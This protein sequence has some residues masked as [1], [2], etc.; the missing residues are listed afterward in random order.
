MHAIVKN[1]RG[2]ADAEIEIAPIALIC[3]TNGQGKTSIARAIGAAASGRVAPFDKLLKKDI[4]VLL[5]HG[6]KSGSV[7]LAGDN[8]STSIAWPK[9][10][11]TSDGL[12]IVSSSIAAGLVDFMTMKEDD[13]YKYLID[14]L[15]AE[16][17]EAD[18]R[19]HMT[20][21]GIEENAIDA[22]WKVIQDRDWVSAHKRAVTK[23][24]EL[25]GAWSQVSGVSFGTKIIDEWFPADWHDSMADVELTS[26]ENRI[27]TIRK[28]LEDEIGSSAVSAAERE[29]LQ[30]SADALEE[31]E[32]IAT[33]KKILV[34]QVEAVLKEVERKL[35][36]TTNPAGAKDFGCPHCDG[37]VQITVISGMG[38]YRLVK[39]DNRALAGEELEK[40]RLEYA[41]LCGEQQNKARAVSD[42]KAALL[43]ADSSVSA[44]LDAKAALLKESSADQVT[45]EAIQTL[46]EKITNMEKTLRLRK[47]FDSAKLIAKQIKTNLKIVELLDEEGIRKTK[48]ADEID[49]FVA[50]F[51]DPICSDMG[52]PVVSIDVDLNVT[53]GTTSYQMLSRAEQLKARI[54]LQMAIAKKENASIIVIDDADTIIDGRSRG[55]LLQAISNI[56]IPTVVCMALPK[57][58]R[59]P[60]LAEMGV[61]QTYWVE[62]GKCRPMGGAEKAAA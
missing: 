40:A 39:A 1:F 6:T 38:E 25:K 51:I 45:P 37:R 32:K 18:F 14:L 50:D 56:D 27:L 53:V 23:G 48:L 43:K 36:E 34:G 13:K 21:A 10:D 41:G 29:R 46:R 47:Q 4:G 8:G 31:N 59:A 3:G 5:R 30:V 55:L 49:R 61:G 17:T 7:M 62:A 33:E 44:S 52:T 54:A 57:L 22:I 9:G 12:P 60:N 42:A 19:E 11:L 2:I 16:P 20:N 15:G 58:D 35:A 24:Q 28:Q 26:L